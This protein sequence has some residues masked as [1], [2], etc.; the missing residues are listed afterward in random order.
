MAAGGAEVHLSVLDV[1][2]GGLDES[3]AVDTCVDAEGGDKTDVRAFRRLDRTE[4]AVMGVV[5]V[6]DL[7]S[8][9]VAAQTSRAECGETPLVGDLRQGVGL[10]HELRE[11]ARSEEGVDHGRE[12]LG[13]DQVGRAELL[14]VADVHLLAYGTGHA[15][16][17]DAELVGEL[18]AHGAHAAVAEVVDIVHRS[19]RVDELDEI[20]DDLDDVRLGQHA[21]VGIDGEVQLL[22]EAVPSH[23][24]EVVALLG[25]E[26]LLDDVAGGVF[27]RR[28]RIA[29]LLVDVVHSL[30]LGVGRILLERVENDIV[31]RGAGLVLL[32]KDG[33]DVGVEDGCYCVVIQ[34]LAAVEEGLGTLDGDDL[35]GI[36]VLEVLHPG[37]ENLGC[38]LA[39]LVLREHLLLDLDLVGKVEDV[40][41]VLVPVE[42]DG[43]QEGGDGK[44]LLAVDV[45][46][47]DIVD[48][49]GELDP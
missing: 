40:D 38:K 42:A 30:D 31:L 48:V 47:H 29:E 17:A 16:E 2:V 7:E 23:V 44:F 12:G 5:H 11:L 25:E 24:A 19:L 35:A 39:A 49:S 15:A 8:G 28:F 43:A 3:E 34:D 21:H 18:L 27:I 13:V 41:D 45:R 22:V 1:T 14:A 4:T 32:E 9:A 36:L 26:E 20:L 33:L 6:S 46:I 10:V 37:L